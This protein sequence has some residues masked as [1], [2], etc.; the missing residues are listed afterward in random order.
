MRNG[1]DSFPVLQSPGMEQWSSPSQAKYLAQ[2]GMQ[3]GS[4]YRVGSPSNGPN[5]RHRNLGLNHSA[6]RFSHGNSRPSSRHQNRE[7]NASSS[8]SVDDPDAFPTL[9]STNTKPSNRKPRAKKA[10]N[11]DPALKKEN[12]PGPLNAIKVS[13]PISRPHQQHCKF[14]NNQNSRVLN[15]DPEKMNASLAIP[16]PKNVP[17]FDEGPRYKEY[18]TYRR[19]AILYCNERLCFYQS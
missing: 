13:T 4:P 8:L 16:T 3:G 10:Q 17:W 9:S 19:D 12:N 6:H 18:I 11:E 2:V 7:S 5:M 14:N 1:H 15:A